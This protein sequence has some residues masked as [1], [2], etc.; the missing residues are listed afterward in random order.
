MTKKKRLPFG[1]E[2]GPVKKERGPPYA[3]RAREKIKMGRNT[4]KEREGGDKI[5]L[6]EFG[7]AR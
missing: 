3:I 6:I 5:L 1:K 7:V 2:V 4:G